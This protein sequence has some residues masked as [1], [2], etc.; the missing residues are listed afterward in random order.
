MSKLFSILGIIFC[1]SLC[2][3]CISMHN[4]KGD[5]DKI[6]NYEKMIATD[7][8]T[9]A[10]LESEYKETTVKIAKIPVKSYDFNYNFKVNDREFKG[11][12]TTFEL[13]KTTSIEVY[14]LPENPAVNCLNPQKLL[15]T[16]LEEKSSNSN[17]YWGIG[18]G[19]LA[20]A[21]VYLVI[22]DFR[23]GRATNN[24]SPT[25]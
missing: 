15:A 19:L 8:K 6:A 5:K 24:T 20:I 22:M 14:Y 1:F 13:P 10:E 11:S 12:Y 17:L 25:V 18:W 3:T 7:S 23:R 4:E 21:N 16:E 2:K 9:M